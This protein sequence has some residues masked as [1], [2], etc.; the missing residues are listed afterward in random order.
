MEVETI[1]AKVFQFHV[2]TTCSGAQQRSFRQRISFLCV[3]LTLS[4]LIQ[5]QTPSPHHTLCNP[6]HIT[7]SR[8]NF[9]VVKAEHSNGLQSHKSAVVSRCR[10]LPGQIMFIDC[11]LNDDIKSKSLSAR[12]EPMNHPCPCSTFVS[13]SFKSNPGG[14]REIQR[15]RQI[16]CCLTSCFYWQDTINYPILPANKQI[17]KFK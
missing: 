5:I 10:Y 2:E 11:W 13:W 3:T 14:Q 17:N 16:P 6:P 12:Y 8:Y 15:D 1:C 4:I 9:L 7:R